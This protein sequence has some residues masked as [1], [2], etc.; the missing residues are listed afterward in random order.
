MSGGELA[1][2]ATPTEFF[3]KICSGNSV[4][5]QSLTSQ[6]LNSSMP[7]KTGGDSFPTP[8]NLSGAA[9]SDVSKYFN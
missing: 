9:R 8:C 7:F 2:Q 3:K 5:N 1:S 6:Y 4:G